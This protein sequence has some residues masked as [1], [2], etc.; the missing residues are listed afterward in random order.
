MSLVV[1]FGVTRLFS[2][3]NNAQ[4]WAPVHDAQIVIYKSEG[5]RDTARGLRG[6]NKGWMMEPSDIFAELAGR[7]CSA[8]HFGIV[9]PGHF[10]G[11]HRHAALDGWSEV[12]LAWGARGKMRGE[13]RNADG[14]REERSVHEER[15]GRKDVVASIAPPG[16]AHSLANLDDEYNLNVLTCT[17]R[18]Y[19]P[20][21]PKTEFHVWPE[22]VVLSP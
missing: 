8:V 17:D 13:V 12:V 7:P 3:A 16:F 14:S 11:N 21:S 6:T 22:D 20:K 19:D 10:R 15:F 4:G 9:K 18:L 1:V 2:T 5:K